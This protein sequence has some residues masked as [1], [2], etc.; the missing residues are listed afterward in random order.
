M[1][2]IV[3]AVAGWHALLAWAHSAPDG[4]AGAWRRRSAEIQSAPEF[5]GEFF[6][7]EQV[8]Q[9]TS[10]W[11]GERFPD[12]RPKVPDDILDRM[13]NCNSGRSMG[14]PAQCRFYAPVRRWLVFD[15]SRSGTGGQG[16]DGGVDAGKARYSEGD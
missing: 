5:H 10:Y 12:G 9:Y 11:T 7:P 2:K 6:T 15:P 16:T 4:A 8:I 13:K 1:R 14:N 3:A